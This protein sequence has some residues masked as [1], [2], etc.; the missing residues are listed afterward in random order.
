M[1]SSVTDKAARLISGFDGAAVPREALHSASLAI[2]DCLGVALAGFEEPVS[3]IIRDATLT[4]TAPQEASIWGTALRTSVLDAALING[5]TAHALDYD[6]QNRSM[7]GHPSSVL[8]PALFAVGEAE[9]LPGRRI[10]E[11]YVLGLQLMARLG[12]VFGQAGYDKSW[13]PTAILGVLGTCASTAYLH[14]LDYETTL[15]AIGIAASE[16]SSIKKNF[17]SMAKPLHVGSAA[18]KGI[19]AARLA[20]AGLTADRQALD[21]KFGFFEMFN[22]RAHEAPDE[23]WTH[24]LEILKTGLVYKQYPCCGGLH[25]LVDNAIAMRAQHGIDA[26]GIE[27]I[28]CRVNPNKTTYLDRPQPK[29]ALD[30]KFSIQYCVATALIDGA[31]GLEHFE[32]GGLGRSDV[33]ALLTKARVTGDASLSSFGC[34]LT[35]QMRDGKQHSGALAEAKGSLK[36]PLTDEELEAKFCDCAASRLGATRARELSGALMTLAT[37][38]DVSALMPLVAP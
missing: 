33:H 31:V 22:G 19:W 28:E 3:R 20:Q 26:K 2:R 17:G 11:A 15:H 10:L 37:M 25:A 35:I 6:D 5:T 30:A 7:L 13:H 29:T 9:G 16:A 27:T 36:F 21:G 38:P 32:G 34:V 23:D 14:G 8:V 4:P 1:T 18:R 12:L 24:P